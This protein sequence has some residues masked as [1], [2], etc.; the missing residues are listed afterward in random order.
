M[1]TLS[2]SSHTLDKHSSFFW[3]SSPSSSRFCEGVDSEPFP[4][5]RDLGCGDGGPDLDELESDY[6]P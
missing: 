6:F 3:Q 5:G 1:Q 4:I 2:S